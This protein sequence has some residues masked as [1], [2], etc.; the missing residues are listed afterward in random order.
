MKTF[1]GVV[2]GFVL[3]HIFYNFRDPGVQ[4]DL[5][6]GGQL[7]GQGLLNQGVGELVTARRTGQLFNH[8]GRQGFL[9]HLE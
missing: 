3:V 5:T 7:L 8:P 2:L 6:G 1:G 4:P 9:Q